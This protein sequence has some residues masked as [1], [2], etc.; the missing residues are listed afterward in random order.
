MKDN[1]IFPFLWMRGEAPEVLRMEMEKIYEAGIRAV[2]LESRPHPD[3][4]GEG[5]WHDVDI[6]IEEARKKRHAD[7]DSG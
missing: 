7:L 4:A 6:I 3:Y 1:H 5:W 2:C